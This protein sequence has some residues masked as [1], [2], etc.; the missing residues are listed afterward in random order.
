[1][2][3]LKNRTRKLVEPWS[4]KQELEHIIPQF[5]ELTLDEI[6]KRMK[7]V[8]NVGSGIDNKSIKGNGSSS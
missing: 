6:K 8:E 1:M 7:K 3:W 5:E 4:D 2:A